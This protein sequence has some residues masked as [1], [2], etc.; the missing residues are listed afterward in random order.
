MIRAFTDSNGVTWRV[1]S[2]IP[3]HTGSTAESYRSGWLTFESR[4]QRRRL[5]PIPAGWEDASPARLQLFCANANPVRWTAQFTPDLPAE[6]E[7]VR[8][9]R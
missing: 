4:E 5:A 1:W 3:V 9:D 6:D 2:T 8:Q 7:D